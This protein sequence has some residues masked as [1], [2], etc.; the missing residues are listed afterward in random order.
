MKLKNIFYY[1]IIIDKNL[2][3]ILIN[4]FLKKEGNIRNY[5]Y[6][7]QLCDS[8]NLNLTFIENFLI[9]NKK[10]HFISINNRLKSL[11]NEKSTHKNVV[12]SNYYG[13]NF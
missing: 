10:K 2:W 13:G 12:N 7:N 6:F 9:M 5:F 4:Y 1:V 11:G 3:I 8:I